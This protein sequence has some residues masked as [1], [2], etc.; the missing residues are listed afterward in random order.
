M[1]YVG[2]SV[3]TEF[4]VTSVRVRVTDD[5]R[6]QDYVVHLT[7]QEAEDAL[8]AG[9]MEDVQEACLAACEVARANALKVQY[10]AE[11]ALAI[12][13]DAKLKA[14]QIIA[15]AEAEAARRLGT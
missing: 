12:L 9:S 13:S 8:N 4:G 1:H 11:E 14:A 2:H 10:P 7:G 6:Q 15:R 3:D 5:A